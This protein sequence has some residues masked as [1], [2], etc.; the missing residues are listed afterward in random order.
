MNPQ[1]EAATIRLRMSCVVE[2]DLL[3][4]IAHM[5]E[6]FSYLPAPAPKTRAARLPE[7]CP[8]VSQH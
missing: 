3:P 1:L 5:P 4:Q 6:A 2:E 8:I 7:F